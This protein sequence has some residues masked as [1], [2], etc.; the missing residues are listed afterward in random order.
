MPVAAD[1][2]FDGYDSDG[3]ND[4]CIPVDLRYAGGE[5]RYIYFRFDTD[6]GE[7]IPWEEFNK[8]GK[9]LIMYRDRGV[10][11]VEDITAG[12]D[13]YKWEN[14]ELVFVEHSNSVRIHD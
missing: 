6:K 10:L 7:Y 11:E 12:I 2:D 1:L 8:V 5:D 4:F 3:C 13:T 14:G 9:K